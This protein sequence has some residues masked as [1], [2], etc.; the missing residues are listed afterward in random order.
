MNIF[1]GMSLASLK[2][3]LKMCTTPELHMKTEEQM[4]IE[5]EGVY[6]KNAMRELL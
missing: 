4:G 2:K 6:S 3:K 5:D 1:S